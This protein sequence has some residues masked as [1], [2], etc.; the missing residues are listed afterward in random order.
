MATVW[1]KG[2]STSRFLQP[3]LE[4]HAEFMRSFL[5]C[6]RHPTAINTHVEDN[7]IVV[8][9]VVVL[10][11]ER[12]AVDPGAPVSLR[13]IVFARRHSVDSIQPN[14]RAYHLRIAEI[15]EDQA[16]L[17]RFIEEELSVT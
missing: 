15:L 14:R 13:Q 10:Q 16:S 8:G 7:V 5:A 4:R 2:V 1:L 17:G 11:D 12:L 6:H 3:T 9:T